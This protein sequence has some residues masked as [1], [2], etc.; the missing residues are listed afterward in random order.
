MNPYFFA[1]FA[2]PPIETEKKLELLCRAA[3]ERKAED[4]VIMEMNQKSAL[5]DFFVVMS[6]SSTV[7]VKAIVDSIDESLSDAGE[8]VRHREGYAEAS[9]VLLD[10]GEVIVH[11]FHHETRKFYNLENLWGDAPK[12]HFVWGAQ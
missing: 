7:R 4:I 11:V 12:R 8:R 5:S 6:A 9:W 3:S 1:T 10:Y 2:R